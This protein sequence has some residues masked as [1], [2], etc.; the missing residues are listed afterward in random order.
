[1]ELTVA[2]L[3]EILGAKTEGN[4]ECHITNFAK[5][6]EANTGDLTFLAN[7]KYTPYIYSTK[8]S[9]VLVHSDFIPENK[10][11]CTL[12]RVND[13]YAALAKLMSLAENKKDKPSGI[14]HP[15]YLSD[16]AVIPDDIYIGAFTYIGKRVR[17]GSASAIYPQ[18]YI[19][20]NV[21]IGKDCIIYA[22]AKIYSDCIIGNRCIIHSGAVIGS[23]GFGFAHT[24]DGYKKI[25]Q[26]G[27][28][29][30]EDDVEIG[31]NTTI[32]RA[33]FGST[34]IGHGTKLDNLVQIA[35]NVV[36][37]SNNVFAAQCGVAGSTHFGN[38]NQ[39]GGQAGFAGHITIGNNNQF[40]AQSGIPNHVDNNNRLMGYPAIDARA[41]AKNL[42]Y[43]K[44]LESLFSKEKNQ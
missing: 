11:N 30:L 27:N 10:I 36:L 8:A 19:G 38:N 41:F 37:G 14:E 6:E 32:D 31:A 7:P 35:H 44:K 9:A 15:V 5:I 39:I 25:P 22:G 2:K 21:T 42:V 29:I 20:D 13:P 40:G 34:K 3:A 24:T 28:V 1:M 23:D 33:T 16:G 43:I 17:I 4:T 26:I 12:I 18:V